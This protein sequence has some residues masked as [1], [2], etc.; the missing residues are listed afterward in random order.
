[1]RK[2][3]EKPEAAVTVF[4]STDMTNAIALSSVLNLTNVPKTDDN[5]VTF[6]K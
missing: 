2:F 3:Y 1:M 5:T 6:P 4:S